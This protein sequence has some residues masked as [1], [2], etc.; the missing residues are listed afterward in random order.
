MNH[1]ICDECSNKYGVNLEEFTIPHIWLGPSDVCE[2]CER[3]LTDSSHTYDKDAFNE[4]LKRAI[5]NSQI[6]REV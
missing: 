1:K 2:L 5:I 3:S 6:L 4:I